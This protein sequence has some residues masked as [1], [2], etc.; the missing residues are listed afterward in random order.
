L[1]RWTPTLE[2]RRVTLQKWN[3]LFEMLAYFWTRFITATA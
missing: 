3:D 2:K 1:S